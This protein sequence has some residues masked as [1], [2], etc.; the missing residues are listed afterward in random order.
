MS[1]EVQ[2]SAAPAGD[3]SVKAADAVDQVVGLVRDKAVKPATTVARVLVYGLLASIAGITA[4]VLV[5][6]AVVRGLDV[7][8]P[9]DVWSAHAVTGGTFSL[10]GLLLW[11]RRSP[12]AD[13][14]PPKRRP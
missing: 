5:A 10:V 3:W 7:A 11:T 6:V 9:G 2:R 14:S 12:K 8:I 13:D 4:A 1:A